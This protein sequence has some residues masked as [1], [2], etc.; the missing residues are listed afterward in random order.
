M[1]LVQFHH[2]PECQISSFPRRLGLAPNRVSRK[3]KHIGGWGAGGFLSLSL[4]PQT[5]LR[6]RSA[7]L[8]LRIWRRICTASV[9]TRR[10]LDAGN[11]PLSYEIR[12]GP[13][14]PFSLCSSSATLEFRSLTARCCSFFSSRPSLS[15]SVRPSSHQFQARLIRWLTVRI[16]W[17]SRRNQPKL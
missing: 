11:Q 5:P 1:T 6:F 17:V 4:K 14:L 8:W 3:K 15:S 16:C 13:F 10:C 12:L 7:S 9:M 2:R